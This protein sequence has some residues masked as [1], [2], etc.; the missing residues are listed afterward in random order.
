MYLGTWRI[1]APLTVA[2]QVELAYAYIRTKT[3]RQCFLCYFSTIPFLTLIVES[4]LIKIY[5]IVI[6]DI[7]SPCCYVCLCYITNFLNVLVAYGHCKWTMEWYLTVLLVE[8]DLKLILIVLLEALVHFPDG[9]LV[10]HLA[11]HERAATWLLHDLLC[12]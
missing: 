1:M 3:S 11:A 8:Q 10:S 5:W 4:V 9:L 12:K 6:Q 2:L 7:Y